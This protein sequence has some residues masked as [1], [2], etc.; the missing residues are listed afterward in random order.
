MKSTLGGLILLDF[1]L[2]INV[3][4]LCMQYIEHGKYRTMKK[5]IKNHNE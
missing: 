4:R 1:Y 3:V 5:N 2:L